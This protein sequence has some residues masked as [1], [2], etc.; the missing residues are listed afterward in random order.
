VPDNYDEN[1]SL[2]RVKET[3]T[4][5]SY[6]EITSLIK[7]GDTIIREYS[8]DSLI[9]E[10]AGLERE[11]LTALNKV[12]V[13]DMSIDQV[14]NEGLTILGNLTLSSVVSPIKI[15]GFSL[16]NVVDSIKTSTLSI[17]QLFPDRGIGPIEELPFYQLENHPRNQNLVTTTQT[18]L[19]HSIRARLHQANEN[20]YVKNAF[21][22]GDNLFNSLA[23]IK[24]SNIERTARDNIKRNLSSKG[25]E[26][27]IVDKIYPIFGISL[28]DKQPQNKWYPLEGLGAGLGPSFSPEELEKKTFNFKMYNLASNTAQSF[29]AYIRTFNESL[30]VTWDEIEFLN[31]SESIEIYQRASRSFTLEFWIFATIDSLRSSDYRIANQGDPYPVSTIEAVT[32]NGIKIIELVDKAE[33][34]NKINFLHS[35]TRPLYGDNNTYVKAP[36]FRLWIGDLIKGIYSNVSNINISYDPL[37]WDLNDD[38]HRPMIAMITMAG[39]FFHGVAPNASDPDFYRDYAIE[40]ETHA[41]AN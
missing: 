37:V 40:E 30:D 16:N 39:K 41:K 14:I 33:M 4:D 32:S 25:A 36:Y 7:N 11:R 34:W 6:D 22:Y 5:L 18:G 35:L 21:E 17:I 29:P 10:S 19:E 3:P 13:I 2:I 8:T 9:V 26:N 15:G 31:R 1:Q 20:T 23:G 24:V 27:N 38:N 28:Q 12:D